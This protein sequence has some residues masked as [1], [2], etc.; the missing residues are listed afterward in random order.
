MVGG[1]VGLLINWLVGWLID[2]LL[3]LNFSS[4]K[5]NSFCYD[6]LSYENMTYIIQATRIGPGTRPSAPQSSASLRQQIIQVSRLFERMDGW[7][8]G[9]LVGRLSID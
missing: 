8:I 3:D 6:Y 4:G 2:W 9:R 7:W 1:L 5:E